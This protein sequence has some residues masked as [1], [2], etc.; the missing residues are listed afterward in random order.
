[1]SEHLLGLSF[2]YLR[3][4]G[5]CVGIAQ[6]P[7]IPEVL[8]NVAFLVFAKKKVCSFD[9]LFMASLRNIEKKKKFKEL[10]VS[11][12]CSLKKRHISDY[13]NR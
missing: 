12:S 2:Q 11:S 10:N 7:E 8:R 9:R 13:T 4:S 3:Y 5:T 1:M 6:S